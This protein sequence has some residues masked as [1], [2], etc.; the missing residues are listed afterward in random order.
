MSTNLNV[1][2][3][4]F[5][6]EVSHSRQPL[7]H[8]SD[9]CQVLTCLPEKFIVDYAN[10]IDVVREHVGEQE[11][12]S[13]M[14]ARFMDGFNGSSHLRQASINAS[15]ADGVEGSL[16]CLQDLSNELAKTNYAVAQVAQ[17]VGVIQSSVTKRANYSADTREI[18]DVLSE[19]FNEKCKEYDAHIKQLNIKQKS[20]EHI[21]LVFSRWGAD[22]LNDLPIA[23]RCYST[24]EELHWGDFGDCVRFCAIHDKKRHSELLETLTNEVVI[25]I[26]N[27]VGIKPSSRLPF[28]EWITPQFNSDKARI[29]DIGEAVLYL[30][31]WSTDTSAPMVN[32]M[33]V[34]ASRTSKFVPYILDSNRL[35]EAMVYEV[36]KGRMI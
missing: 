10:G 8:E 28:E 3:P 25:Q 9:V 15:L 26:K 27:D 17:R 11:K 31:D 34:A 16:L 23:A 1:E 4:M 32:S 14:F 6:S 21:D 22:K 24:L 33:V 5:T 13:G 19:R 7:T 36:F 12:R 30:A 20:K 35:A 2:A 29:A 18:V